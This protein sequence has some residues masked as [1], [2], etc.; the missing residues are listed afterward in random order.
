[1]EAFASEALLDRAA[2][3]ASLRVWLFPEVH[4][5]DGRL[6]RQPL[7]GKLLAVAVAEGKK[8][9]THLLVGSPNASAAALLRTGANVECALHLVLDGHY[10][11]GLLCEE[12]VWVPREQVTLR[13][14]S[15]TV[16]APSPARWV[17][18]AVFDARERCV[19]VTWRPSA[20]RLMLCYPTTDRRILLDSVPGT[21]SV[22]DEFDL[23]PVCCELEVTDPVARA[24]ARV[25]LRIEHAL[26]LPVAGITGELDLQELLL[27][28]A[29]RYTPVG[30]AARRAATAAAGGDAS[31]VTASIFGTAL[32]PREVFRALLS[33]GA[34]LARAPSIGAFQAQ[35][36]GPWGVC[37]LAERIV[38]AP[39]RGEL[40]RAEAWI[41]AQELARVLERVTF[42]GDPTGG[43][44]ATLRD[45][46]VQWI[47]ENVS[48]PAPGTPG[49]SDL[50][51]FYQGAV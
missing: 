38:E 44:K 47:R 50:S 11:L 51:S 25:P 6:Y 20:P 43:D 13:G 17:D 36:R 5:R 26:D 27:L 30:I 15:Y 45:E 34:E 49:I 41:Y 37:R 2:L 28:H 33:I 42:D 32:S 16:L 7:H 14:R 10:H 3:R 8:K 24:T 4:R 18:D 9:R 19:R 39:E 35:L 22:F 48:E 46:V 12:L 31:S 21:E 23:D 29:G 1:V 40:M